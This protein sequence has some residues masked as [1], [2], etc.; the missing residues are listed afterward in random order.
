MDKIKSRKLWVAIASLL[1]IIITD[2]AGVDIDPETYWAIVGVASIYIT[3][4][5]I[6]DTRNVK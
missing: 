4:Q 2:V 6:V 5:S 3:G 1:F